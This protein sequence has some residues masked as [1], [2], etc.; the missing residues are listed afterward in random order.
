MEDVLEAS[1]VSFG[2]FHLDPAAGCVWCGEHAL[3]LTPKAFAVLTYL[4]EQPGRLITKDELLSAVWRGTIVSDAALKVQIRDIRKV[5]GDNSAAP[6]YIA[7]VPW[8][9]YRFIAPVAAADA[10]AGSALPT[11][12]FGEAGEAAP[13][14][15]PVVVGRES[16]LAALQLRFAQVMQSQR[17]TVFV[18]GEAGIGKTTLLETFVRQQ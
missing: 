16:E 8:R 13:A 1:G 3:A 11:V 17:Q 6:Q 14:E 10:S 18:T 5:L 7:T 12:V 15:L 4:V 2:P 9:G